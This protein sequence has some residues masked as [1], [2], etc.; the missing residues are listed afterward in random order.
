MP[1]DPGQRSHFSE[2]LPSGP[3]GLR[4]DQGKLTET[5]DPEPFTSSWVAFHSEHE[6]VLEW[7][8]RNIKEAGVQYPF[9][10]VPYPGSAY[11][12]VQVVLGRELLLLDWQQRDAI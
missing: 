8:V 3:I 11:F 7:N 9:T 1:G 6:R 2:L 4:A 12:E 5:F 10:F